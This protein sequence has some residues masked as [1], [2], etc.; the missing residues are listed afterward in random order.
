[1][2]PSDGIWSTD[3]HRSSFRAPNR[4]AKTPIQST[5][6]ALRENVLAV[7]DPLSTEHDECIRKFEAISERVEDCTPELGSGDFGEAIRRQR[8]GG[9]KTGAKDTWEG[10]LSSGAEMA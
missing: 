2:S 3:D 9:R 10:A 6:D 1:M 4:V 7:G 8:G 5:V